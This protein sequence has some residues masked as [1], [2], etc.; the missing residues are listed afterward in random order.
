MKHPND[1]VQMDILSWDH[2]IYTT[3]PVREI[4]L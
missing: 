3:N 4:I 2:S 1:M